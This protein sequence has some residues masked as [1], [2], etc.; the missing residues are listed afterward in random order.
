[1]EE[2]FASLDSKIRAEPVHAS[3]AHIRNRITCNDCEKRSLARFH[4]HHHKCGHCGS[5]NTS[6]LENVR[7]GADEEQVIDG[8]IQAPPADDPA[9]P[10]IAP[11]AV[12]PE[13]EAH[14][15]NQDGAHRERERERGPLSRLLRGCVPCGPID[16]RHML[17]VTS[18]VA[19]AAAVAIHVM[20]R[21]AGAG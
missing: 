15:N 20:T 1:M 3:H 19:V 6:V 9:L 16:R 2:W 11:P 18:C 5:Y 17:V 14:T 13:D 7:V 4:H 12:Q 21:A 10:L 8:D